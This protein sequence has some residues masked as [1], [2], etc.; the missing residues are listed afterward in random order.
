MYIVKC[1][2]IKFLKFKDKNRY[3]Q[4][5][6]YFKRHCYLFSGTNWTWEIVSML[7]KE[8]AEYQKGRKRPTILEHSTQE[9]FEKMASPRV[10]S[11]HLQF[12][13]IPDDIKNRKCKIVY[14]QRNP[15][16]VCVSFHKFLQSEMNSDIPWND[17]VNLFAN[18]DEGKVYYYYLFYGY[19]VRLTPSPPQ[20]IKN[21]ENCLKLY[22]IHVYIYIVEALQEYF[23]HIT[24]C[25]EIQYPV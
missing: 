23:D 2:L 21:R 17:Y 25:Y 11:T 15:K 16:D 6:Y 14:V 5:L 8:A 9:F 10:L 24:G 4:C 22:H 7:T 12:H 18:A 13:H 1:I 20:I 3:V 19:L